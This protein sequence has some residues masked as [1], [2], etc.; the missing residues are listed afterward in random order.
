M[1]D[2]KSSNLIRTKLVGGGDWFTR[3]LKIPWRKMNT[4]LTVRTKESLFRSFV[5][6]SI[7]DL[8]MYE[9]VYK[10]RNKQSG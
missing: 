3:F 10:R 1:L 4:P 6:T 9:N 8:V 7:R 2:A 5:E